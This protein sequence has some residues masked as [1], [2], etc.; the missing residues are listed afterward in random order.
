MDSQ[1]HQTTEATQPSEM[2]Q[3]PDIDETTD[4]G[5]GSGSG[6][7]SKKVVKALLGKKGA[8]KIAKKVVK[9]VASAAFDE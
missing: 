1:Q 4:R 2:T 6:G 9:G 5:F 3:N 8:L 7:K